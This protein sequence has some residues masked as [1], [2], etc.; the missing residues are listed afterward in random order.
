[1]LFGRGAECTA[2]ENVLVEARQSRSA[3][4]VIR[5]EPGM[6]KSALLAH[7]VE[8]ASG[9]R[10]LRGVGIESESELPFA[11]LHGIVRP[12]LDL[13][14]RLPELQAAALRA[15]FGLSAARSDDRF[16]IAVGVLSL[17]SEA[18]E[19]RPVLCAVDDAHWLD[20]ASA[21]ALTFAARRL[22]A[23][24]VAL[25]F[26]ARE[27]E[28]RTFPAPG[29]PELRLAGLD[30]DAAGAL[31]AAQQGPELLPRLRDRLIESTGG[32][33]LALLELSAAL[34]PEQRAGR[35]LLPQPP[36]IGAALEQAFLERVRRL[37][38][39]SQTLLLLA[40]ADDTGDVGTVLRA[41]QALGATAE[42]LDAAEAAGLLR[43]GTSGLE[44]RHPLVRSAV[45]QG[46]AFSARR[47]AHQ[48]LADAFERE[49]D[50]DRRAWHRAA[51]VTGPS[52]EVAA[53]LERSSERAQR[54]G[55][56]AA[57]GAALERAA[58]LTAGDEER[59]RRLAAA[60]DSASRGGDNTR[61]AA[62]VDRAARIAS[63]PRLV[64]DIEHLRGRVALRLGAIGDAYAILT[65]GA[66]L[67]ATV[68]PRKATEMLLDAAEAAEYGGNVAQLIEIGRRSSTL[69]QTDGHEFEFATTL[70]AGM[71]SMLE[72]DTARGAQL[73]HRAIA[74]AEPSDDP[75][76]LLFAGLGAEYLG[77]VAAEQ[78][79]AVR[80]TA[81]LRTLGAVGT[82][83]VALE[84]LATAEA[85]SGQYAR[86]AADA[87]EGLRLA[88]DT[89]QE[90]AACDFLALLALVA[91]IQGREAD[92]RA[93]AAQALERA[94][95]HSLGLPA[96]E[97]S[98]ALALLDLGLGR[99]AHALERLEA[100][101]L[102]APGAGHPRLA[103]LAAPNLV[104]AA[105]LADRIDV[106]QTAL[107]TFERWVEQ[108]GAPP[109]LPLLARCRGQ[110]SA[111]AAAERH[112]TEALRLHA[113][114][115][116]PFE[117]A[118]TQLVYG[119]ALRR[120]RR[121]REARVHLRAALE[122]FGRVGAVPWEERARRELRAT[123][124]TARKRD[125]STIDLLTPQEL[126]I[127]RFVADGATNREVAAQLFLSPR[128]I[129]Y[130]LRKIF[131]KLGISSRAELI[132][133]GPDGETARQPD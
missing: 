58:E 123:G 77:D 9:M 101:A 39:Q 122:T 80:A 26:A 61:A 70:L 131:Q 75:R 93:H 133:L 29:I 44:F 102:A 3:A 73:L 132:R 62:L 45:Y 35:E 95:V 53:E 17:L 97:A 11:A 105:V 115:D 71:G 42:A 14:E 13:V 2:V 128:T 110:L 37:P 67:I 69:P 56:Y 52:D 21:D 109:M 83:P 6:G 81:L 66:T 5:G 104:E 100:L 117:R 60:A 85:W 23:D 72:A 31:L 40:A 119:E 59:A 127:S 33:P 19:E 126:Q 16:L 99:P 65:T 121:R 90:G 103:L 118:R 47:A 7:A 48:A 20:H 87:T 92:C 125:P 55:G 76:L 4:L 94:A 28:A 63:E 111:G 30:G 34:T 114:S 38:A 46:A 116:R 22:E 98:H 113:E 25:L 124:E 15:A 91:A 82:L 12:V 32:N 112:F 51:A 10:V 68:D 79:F 1:M 41:G 84:M 18:A 78:G 107:A 24:G 129:D 89:G 54:R 120:A 49:Q 108:V 86:A 74:L 106:A 27:G 43:A 57:A 88:G 64:A 8:H 50:I 96:A 130:H 36:P